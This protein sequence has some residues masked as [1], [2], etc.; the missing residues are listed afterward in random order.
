M[1]IRDYINTC[2]AWSHEDPVPV[3]GFFR[4]RSEAAGRP[5]SLEN[6]TCARSSG[7]MVC[8]AQPPAR[9][10]REFVCVVG[11]GQLVAAS[12]LLEQPRLPSSRVLHSHQYGS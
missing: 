9:P 10:V 7:S 6:L 5:A 2:I 8:S 1:E 4:D 3:V 11:R 12:P